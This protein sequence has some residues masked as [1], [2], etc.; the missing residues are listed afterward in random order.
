MP[1]AKRLEV[2][3]GDTTVSLSNLDKLDV[4]PRGVHQG[5]RDRL[6]HADRAGPAA[7][8]CATRPLTLKRYPNGVEV[9]FFYGQALPGD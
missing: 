4:P 9:K 6:R 3:V 1:P 8:I 2:N 7:R 5:P